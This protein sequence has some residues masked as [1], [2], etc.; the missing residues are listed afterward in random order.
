MGLFR[1]TLPISEGNINND[2]DF[3]IKRFFIE[4]SWMYGSFRTLA[5]PSMLWYNGSTYSLWYKEKVNFNQVGILKQ[6]D[7]TLI[8]SIVNDGTDG[9]EPINHPAPMLHINK[10]TGYIYVLQNKFHVDEIRVWRS[11]NPEDISSFDYIGAFGQGCSYLGHLDGNDSDIVIQTRAGDVT[12][13]YS[14]SIIKVNLDTLVYTQTVI[15]NAD[16]VNSETRHYLLVPYQYGESDK[17]FF[18][19]AHR[20][21]SLANGRQGYYKFSLLVTDKGGDYEIFENIDSSFSKDVVNTSIL[22]NTE[23]DNN[24]VVLGDELDRNTLISEGKLIALNDDVYIVYMNDENSGRYS[25]RKFTYGSSTTTDFLIP[26]TNI[27]VSPIYYSPVYMRYNGTNFVFT[28]WQNDINGNPLTKI[29]A[30]DTNFNNWTEFP[31]DLYS[32]SLQPS[33]GSGFFYG[34]PENLDLAVDSDERYLMIGKDSESTEGEF[35]FT[36]TKNKWTI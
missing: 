17:T 13:F 32:N 20:N 22:T 15:T 14:M 35:N 4:D 5:K 8:S 2:N 27:V 3:P 16:S 23:L 19:I 36:V 28:I 11:A 25:V 30:C 10:S 29:Y 18:G 24:Y 33:P 26:V 21:Q 6:T 31:L 12:E 1:Q 9:I 34:M 7:E